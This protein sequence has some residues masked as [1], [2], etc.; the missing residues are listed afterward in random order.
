MKKI[1]AIIIS[2]IV[3]F[4]LSGILSGCDKPKADANTIEVVMADGTT[5]IFQTEQ[6]EQ[7]VIT[8]K[9][10]T[11][12][13]PSYSNKSSFFEF[14]HLFGD[15]VA[16]A[17]A[18]HKA[19]V[20]GE[21]T[22]PKVDLDE[23]SMGESKT[24]KTTLAS[25]EISITTRIWTKIK[26]LGIWIAIG[27]AAFLLLPVAFPVLKPIF[28][29]LWIAVKNIFTKLFSALPIVGAFIA[30]HFATKAAVQTTATTEIVTA[31]QAFK[32]AIRA[33]DKLTD[34]AKTYILE[35]FASSHDSIHSEATD[36]IVDTIKKNT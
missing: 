36:T 24:K 27:G 17:S 19:P 32:D 18:S 34:D 12:Q 35:I 1:I 5:Q 31:D 28:A 23:M 26:D 33:S 20:M 7:V 11:Y 10:Y 21:N 22:T 16:A 2:G 15:G 3:F 6:V 4:A 13:A 9:E 25:D 29:S 30:S 14:N 8:P